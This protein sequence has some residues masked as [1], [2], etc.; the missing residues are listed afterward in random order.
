M[1]Q[2]RGHGDVVERERMNSFVQRKDSLSILE[3]PSH[4]ATVE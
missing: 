4:T 3:K 2:A 1:T